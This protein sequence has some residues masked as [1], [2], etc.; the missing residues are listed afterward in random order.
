MRTGTIDGHGLALR[1]G[2]VWLGR[3]HVRRGANGATSTWT[4]A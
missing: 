4:R 1:L 3:E 2:K